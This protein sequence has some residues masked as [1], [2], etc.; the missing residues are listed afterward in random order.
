MIF[1]LTFIMEKELWRELVNMS[2]QD[3]RNN[4]EKVHEIIQKLCELKREK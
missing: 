3:I 4:A 2:V 1:K